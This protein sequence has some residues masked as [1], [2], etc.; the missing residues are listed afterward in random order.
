MVDPMSKSVAECMTDFMS[1]GFK[2]NSPDQI[3]VCR[4]R[5]HQ[6]ISPSTCQFTCQEK[7]VE[8]M[9]IL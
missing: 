3:E 7:I 2:W 1:H 9:F 5:C 8:P 4:D 6:T